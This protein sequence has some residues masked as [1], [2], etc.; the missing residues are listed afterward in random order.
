MGFSPLR[1]TERD[2]LGFIHPWHPAAYPV[3]TLGGTVVEAGGYL[4]YDGGQF[5]CQSN[6]GFRQSFRERVKGERTASHTSF[7]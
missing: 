4:L 3:W 6:V 7:F 1:H 2:K 5:S